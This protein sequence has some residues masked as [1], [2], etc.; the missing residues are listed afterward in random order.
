MSFFN[1]SNKIKIIIKLHHLALLFNIII[2]QTD[3]INYYKNINYSHMNLLI[4]LIIKIKT[5]Y[6]ISVIYFININILINI[7]VYFKL[8]IL[9]S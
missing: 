7:L 3:V 1:D 5:I 2:I 4:I 6:V 9:L 8:I